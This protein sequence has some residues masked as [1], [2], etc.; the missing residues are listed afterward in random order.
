MVIT[1]QPDTPEVHPTVDLNTATTVSKPPKDT[2]NSFASRFK[3]CSGTTVGD[4]KLPKVAP[5]V[6]PPE[7][8]PDLDFAGDGSG[9]DADGG[10]VKG[11][12]KKAKA[13]Y[14]DYVDRRE[15]ATWAAENPDN[16]LATQTQA[17]FRSK[18][19]DPNH[20]ASIDPLGSYLTNGLTDRVHLHSRARTEAA[21]LQ[22]RNAAADAQE[23]SKAAQA[24][25]QKAVAEAK[26]RDDAALV[27]A[28][29]ARARAGYTSPPLPRAAA[30][31]T[32][33]Y[34]GA[35]VPGAGRGVAAPVIPPVQLN[36]LSQ[37]LVDGSQKLVETQNRYIA[38]GTKAL[39]DVMRRD[40]TYLMVVN[41]SDGE[42]Q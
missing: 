1:W 36:A 10:G 22:A 20:P 38:A 5:L 23:R 30:A 29:Q 9:G 28:M 17:T 18:Y 14:D 32:P 7:A 16:L 21:Q 33:Q 13:S 3:A 27:Q 4:F 24:Q 2:S 6:F 41:L 40:M 8:E 19:S 11:K 42:Q 37:A 15:Q 25:A 12:F 26:A 31:A 39:Q 34:G 35:V